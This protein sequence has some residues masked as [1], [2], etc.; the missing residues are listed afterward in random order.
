MPPIFDDPFDDFIQGDGWVCQPGL[1]VVLT[2]WDA[3]EATG[4]FLI[5]GRRHAFATNEVL[6]D[7]PQAPVIGAFYEVYPR[8]GS[9][10]ERAEFLRPVWDL[11]HPM[12]QVLLAAGNKQPPVSKE[13]EAGV[14][15]PLEWRCP[16]D[17]NADSF[18]DVL[19]YRPCVSLLQHYEFLDSRFAPTALGGVR[20]ANL[21]EASKEPRGVQ[22]P[23]DLQGGEALLVDGQILADPWMNPRPVDG[24]TEQAIH[25]KLPRLST[26][27][28]LTSGLLIVDEAG[29]LRRPP[30]GKNQSPQ[31]PASIPTRVEDA[32][33]LPFLHRKRQPSHRVDKRDV[34]EVDT[35]AVVV[36]EEIGLASR[37]IDE[38]TVLYV[39]A[40]RKRYALPA[41]LTNLQSSE[42][43]G[44][45]RLASCDPDDPRRLNLESI[46]WAGWNHPMWWVLYCM[47]KG[48]PR[49]L[50][51][52][53]E[54]PLAP[55]IAH[56]IND[57]VSRCVKFLTSY[58]LVE[59][60]AGSARDTA[61]YI[62]PL[63]HMAV[64]EWKRESDNLGGLSWMI[65]KNKTLSSLCT[66]STD[67]VWV[68]GQNLFRAGVL[69]LLL[70]GQLT[71]DEDGHPLPVRSE[72]NADAKV[73]E[74]DGHVR[75][76][77]NLPKSV[78]DRLERMAARRGSDLSAVVREVLYQA[79]RQEE[80]ERIHHHTAKAF[81]AHWDVGGIRAP[82]PELT[83]G[84]L[85]LP[86]IFDLFFR[87]SKH[88]AIEAKK[89]AREQFAQ[90]KKAKGDALRA[91]HVR[92]LITPEA[93]CGIAQEELE[94]R[95]RA[96]RQ[97]L[98]RFR[99]DGR[100]LMDEY[101][102]IMEDLRGQETSS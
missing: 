21:K 46:S 8:W 17:A 80:A 33:G 87:E 64:R 25:T 43:S 61:P 74:P 37:T 57:V 24:K 78:V 65:E 85:R 29:N 82:L 35:K 55:R 100:G 102:C 84:Q 99:E 23:S 91:E 9:Y 13:E 53:A 67:D 90:L 38:P 27:H 94:L 3:K 42:W 81:G 34:D 18:L 30:A 62:T 59:E 50:L 76:T 66:G 75:K 19:V 58:G 96:L 71:L 47:S 63:G 41:Y 36:L 2:A 5:E 7:D 92:S 11:E 1:V 14:L 83:E 88:L 6:F 79:G 89:H 20:I 40:E 45:L 32:N 48:S 101:L 93:I 69:G 31:A 39:P 72:A 56:A 12:W 70:E 28:L 73:I 60:A 10:S 44:P 52:M 77:F 97:L 16:T 22:I 15:R 26:I 86:P 98:N 4:E 54:M 68:P 95:D 49:L 51:D